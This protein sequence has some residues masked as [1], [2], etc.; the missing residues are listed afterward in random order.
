MSKNAVKFSTLS[1]PE[2]VVFF[3]S[4]LSDKKAREITAL[5]LSAENSLSEA[6]I[7]VTASS[8][9]HAQGLADNLLKLSREAGHEF[10]SLEGYNVGQWILLDFNDVIIHIFQADYRDLFRLDDLWSSAPLMAGTGR[11]EA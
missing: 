6:V 10:L 11:R 3:I 8:A 1:T 7:I 9:R 4:I 5:D 2:K